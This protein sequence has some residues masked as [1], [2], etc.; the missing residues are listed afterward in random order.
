MGSAAAYK[1]RLQPREIE[2]DGDVWVVRRMTKAGHARH[3][4]GLQL[5]ADVKGGA[6]TK[7]Q[8]EASERIN[9]AVFEEY[10]QGIKNPE[11][12]E[13]EPVGYDELTVETFGALWK[14]VVETPESPKAEE[15][16]R[17]L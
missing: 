17:A 15:A 9:K 14:A 1:A 11:S 6:P 4:S 13:I 10:V 8:L 16:R 5:L 7:E 2:I 12:G 3:F